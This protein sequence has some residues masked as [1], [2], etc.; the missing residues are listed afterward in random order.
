MTSNGIFRYGS[1]KDH[2]RAYHQI[3]EKKMCFNVIMIIVQLNYLYIE[4]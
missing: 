2:S 1:K 4:N 3:E